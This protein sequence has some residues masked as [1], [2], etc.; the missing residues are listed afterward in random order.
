[1][2]VS[3]QALGPSQWQ[4][5]L[6]LLIRQVRQSAKT[7]V[8]R[9]AKGTAAIARKEAPKASGLLKSVLAASQA[10]TYLDDGLTAIVGIASPSVAFKYAPFVEGVFNGYKL[11]RRP[12]RRP[13]SEPIRAWVKIKNIAGKWGVSEDSAVFLVRRKIGREGTPAQ[14]FMLPATNVWI[15]Q[16]K[17][18]IERV[19]KQAAQQIGNLRGAAA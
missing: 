2:R 4:Q 8:A 3:T 12:G 11:G 7:E 16:F 19:F 6:R 13:P 18:N 1:M 9:A 17:A 14:P 10:V 5:G 15:P